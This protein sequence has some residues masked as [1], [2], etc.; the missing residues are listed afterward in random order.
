MYLVDTNVWL[1]RLL[2]QE[3]AGEV[4]TFLDEVPAGELLLTDFSFHSI[5]VA[6][7]RLEKREWLQRFTQDVLID[8][9]VELVSLEPQD[10]ERLIEVMDET[11]LDFD[12]AYQYVAAEKRSAD[13]VS[14][15]GD[16]DG[17]ERGKQTPA[18]VVKAL[19]R[20]RGDQQT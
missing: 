5:G 6:L 18:E 8:G 9:A 10:I 19:R 13:L 12:D 1:E 11:G 14:F 7:D 17:T 4:G 2:D 16:F 20:S 3:K 15:D